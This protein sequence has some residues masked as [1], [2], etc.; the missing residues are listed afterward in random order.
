MMKQHITAVSFDVD[1]TLITPAFA[2]LIWL[3]V[4]PQLVSDCW[5]IDLEDAK[6]KLFADYESLGPE[7]PEWYDLPYWLKRYRLEV[8]PKTLVL[9]YKSA[10]TPY[11]EVFDVLERLKDKY[12]LIVVSNSMRLFLDVATDGLK[13]YFKHIFS[14]LSDFGLMKDVAAYQ[15]VSE[16]LGINLRETAHVGD[17]FV[18][19][20]VKAK[21]AGLRAFYLDR[22]GIR[23]GRYFVKNLKELAMRLG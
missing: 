5:K 4:L 7:R 11:P 13:P 14:T 16:R 18:L 21:R 1:G 19:D 10:V 3:E 22:K 23:H 2:D 6:N 8:N 20:Y 17:N 15:A 12:D 9:Q